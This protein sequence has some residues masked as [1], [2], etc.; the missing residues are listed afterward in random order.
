MTEEVKAAL[1]RGEPSVN[2]VEQMSID[3]GRLLSATFPNLSRLEAEVRGPRFLDRMQGG[4]WGPVGA[5]GVDTFPL[6]PTSPVG[7]DRVAVRETKE[8]LRALQSW[9]C[10][11]CG[12]PIINLEQ[13]LLIWRSSADLFCP[14]V[15]NSSTR[16]SARRTAIPAAARATRRRWNWRAYLGPE[17]LTQLLAFLSLGPLLGPSDAM[18]RVRDFD[19][20]VDLLRR[21]QV[22][23][24]EEA[25]PH[26][27]DRRRTRGPCRR[28]R[29]VPVHT[30]GARSGSPP[31]SRFRVHCSTS[32]GYGRVR[33]PPEPRKGPLTCGG[34][35]GT[36][37]PN[38]LLAKQVRYQ[39]RH[40]PWVDQCRS[41]T[42]GP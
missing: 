17:G 11:T 5:Y 30:D 23:Y 14:W 25:R 36:R 4:W 7:L 1:E 6:A 3:F 40:G 16:I 26:F 41:R 24:Y 2:H 12:Q 15:P 39:L 8:R 9:T 22:P 28:K 42:V 32:L 38:P 18:P 35:K 29:V 31:D 19:E 34:A 37:T 21:L 33:G 20:F 27:G 13:A 10:D